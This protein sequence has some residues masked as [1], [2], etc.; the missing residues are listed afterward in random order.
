M[1]RPCAFNSCAFIETAIVDDGLI[2]FSESAMK[3]ME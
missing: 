3:P 1:S 2:L